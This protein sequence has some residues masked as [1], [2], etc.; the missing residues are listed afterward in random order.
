M[1]ED[2]IQMQKFS[3]KKQLPAS[4]PYYLKKN[5]RTH[6]HFHYTDLIYYSSYSRMSRAFKPLF[7]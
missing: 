2:S 3:H 7:F 5:D 6:Y 4:Q 1:Q